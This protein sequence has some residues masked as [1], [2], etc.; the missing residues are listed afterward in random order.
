MLDRMVDLLKAN[1]NFQ[2]PGS[3]SFISFLPLLPSFSLIS[4][5]LF[6]FFESEE[7]GML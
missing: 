3:L 5:I 2:G 4:N 1:F 6:F 7:R